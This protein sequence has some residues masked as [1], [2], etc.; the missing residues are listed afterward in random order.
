VGGNLQ[1]HPVAWVVAAAPQPVSL[2]AAESPANLARWLLLRRGMLTSNGGEALG[3]VRSDPGLSAPDLE[4]VFVPGPTSAT[5]SSGR[6]G[7]G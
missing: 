6:P 3:F 2:A 5:C 1:D 4:L 7:T